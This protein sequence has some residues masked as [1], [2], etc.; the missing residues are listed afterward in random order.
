MK[1]CERIEKLKK[2]PEIGETYK[3]HLSVEVAGIR[4]PCYARIRELNGR[5]A[6]VD[7]REKT[8]DMFSYSTR[9]L[10]LDYVAA[11]EAA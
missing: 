2:F 8:E 6:L 5:Y 11:E 3:L 9:I 10:N 1:T 7:F 4:L